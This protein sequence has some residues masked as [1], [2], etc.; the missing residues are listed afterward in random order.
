MRGGFSNRPPDFIGIGFQRCATSWLH[1]TLSEH[2]E[3]GK[4]PRG[5][6]FF[7]RDENY[8]KGK[9]WYERQLGGYNKKPV[10]GEFSVSY[11]YPEVFNK[12]CRRINGLYP[13]A[14]IL[15]TVRNPVERAYSDYV[16]SL[17]FLELS[18]RISFKR[19]IELHPVFIE[20]G[21]YGKILSHYLNY[22][23]DN[24]Y[25]FFYED[26]KNNPSEF[27]RGIY[28]FLGASDSYS[29]S[30][31]RQGKVKKWR[32]RNIAVQKTLNYIEKSALEMLGETGFD[33]LMR[34]LTK[35]G[36]INL[37]KKSTRRVPFS[38]DNDIKSMLYEIYYDDVQKLS[39]LTG[40]DLSVWK[41]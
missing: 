1:A 28:S 29:P 14:K 22:F 27:A 20:R 40:K 34:S 13:Q 3:I 2:P 38:M 5:L 11:S 32:P 35:S 23:K 31:I 6:H 8:E 39:N 16:R 4:P 17:R 21:F 12:S 15:C 18:R 30:N 10:V 26:L 41:E 19:A 9:E 33:K 36:V 25:V 24:L 37:L 7:S